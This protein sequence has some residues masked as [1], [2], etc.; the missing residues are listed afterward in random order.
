LI[1]IYLAWKEKYFLLGISQQFDRTSIG[2]RTSGLLT[3]KNLEWFCKIVMKNNHRKHRIEFSVA[4]S[5]APVTRDK[6]DM[7]ANYH[8]N[9]L[10]M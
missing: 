8:C 6:L 2:G 10:T 3:S 9:R 1:N 7:L 4:F 5:P